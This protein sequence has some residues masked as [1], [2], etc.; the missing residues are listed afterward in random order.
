MQFASSLSTESQWSTAIDEVCRLALQQ[1]PGA[2]DLA[3]LFVSH[4]HEDGFDRIASQVCDRIGSEQLLGCTGESIVGVGREIEGMPAIS[5]WLAQLPDVSITPMQ[6]ALERTGPGGAIVGWPDSLPETWPNGAAMVVLGEPFTFP[7]DFLLERLNHEQ[8][9]VPVV[10]GMASGAD[11][12]GQNRLFLGPRV[13]DSG[14]VAVVA[15]G[16]FQL[17]AVVSQ[18]CRPIGQPYVITQADRN[19]I[20]QLGGQ[21]ALTRLREVFDSLPTHEQL[22]VQQGLH[23]GR[24][25]SEYQDSFEP[26]DF[27]VRNVVGIDQESGAVAVGDHVRAGQTVQFHI[28]DQK[29]ADDDLRQLLA[30]AHTDA[31]SSRGALLFTCN[32][33]G[34]RLFDQA[35]HDARAIQDALGDIPLA[36]FFAQGE[37]GPVAGKN[38]VHG[39]T[40]SLALFEP[41]TRAAESSS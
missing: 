16:A 1:L 17:R 30:Q 12:P 4:H 40:A 29:T 6:L 35:H 32:G 13:L 28:R 19:L 26:G 14:A 10:G 22:L 5:L 37:L 8:S 11:S 7:A 36:G 3:L 39:F 24:V 15:H 9:H 38:F 31:T 2:P 18:G 34:T 25:V 33:R 41:A 21:S 27:L 20:I 23:V